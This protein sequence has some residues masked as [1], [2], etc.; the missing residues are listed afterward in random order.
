MIPANHRACAATVCLAIAAV[1]ASWAAC[2]KRPQDTGSTDKA[3]HAAVADVA[4][5]AHLVERERLSMGSELRVT[6]WTADEP[7]ALSAFDAVFTEFNRL[8]A[9]MTVWRE[10]SDIERLNAAAGDHAVPVSREV[11]EVLGVAHQVSDLTG[12]KFDVTFAA[13]SDLWRFDQDQNNSIPDPEEVRRRLPLIDYHALELDERAGTAFLK[14]KGMRVNLGGI[15]KGYAVGRAVEILR[16]LGFRD[17]LVQSGGDMYA[18]GHRG[19]RPWRL[20]IQD[21]RGPAD[22][23]FATIDLSDSTLSTSGDYER[24]FVRNGRRYHHIIDP[25]TGEP[26]R[27]CRSVTIMTDS[28]VIS[29]GLD[30]GVFVMGPAAGM[31]LLERLHVDGVIVTDKNEVLVT[32]GVKDRL[33]MLATPTDAP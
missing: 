30:T 24:S 20:G 29:D 17:F 16:R 14:R 9:L 8:E 2:T 23:S 1:T 4:P 27:G 21:P 28:P 7:A 11:L 22:T 5:G 32:P 26:A 12:G 10:T 18:A 31:A 33:V 15:G 3:G 6:A 25:A 13:L 19:D